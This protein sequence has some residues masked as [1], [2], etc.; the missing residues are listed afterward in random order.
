MIN[1][2][3]SKCIKCKHFTWKEF[4]EIW[5]CKKYKDP[6]KVVLYFNKCKEVK[7]EKSNNE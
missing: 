1:L 5:Y 7:I 4:Q 2:M 3:P 6:V